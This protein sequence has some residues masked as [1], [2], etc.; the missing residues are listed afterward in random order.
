MS[1]QESSQFLTLHPLKFKEAV[2]KLLTV[3]PEPKKPKK[4]RRKS[5]EDKNV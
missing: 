3:K 4:R 2:A 5:K 1:R